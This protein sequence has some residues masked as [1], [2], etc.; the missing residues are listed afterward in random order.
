[1]GTDGIG[2]DQFA[3][4]LRGARSRSQIAVDRRLRVPPLIGVIVGAIAGLLP[5]LARRGPDALHRPDPHD[6]A[7]RRRR[8]AR[9]ATSA[10]AD[11]YRLGRDPRR[12]SR[13]RRWPASSAAEFLSLRE[14]E[15]V[16]AARA[17]GASN[18]RI[19]FK[20]MLPNVVGSIIVTA[21]LIMATAI[22][23]ETA[24]SFLGLGVKPPGH[25]A[26]HAG[27][28]ATRR[29]V[30]T[31]P[32]LFY[33]P[34]L[35][36]IL[37]ALCVN[38]IGDG[39]RDAFDPTADPGAGLMTDAARGRRPHR[40][41]PDRRRR[42]ARRP[43]RVATTL[44]PRRGARH[45]RRV[46]LGQVGVVAWRSWACCR[47]RPAYRGLD[48]V[49][50]PGA[51]R[52]EA[53]RQLQRLRGDEHRDDLPGPDDVAEPRV[54]GRAGSSPRRCAPTTTCRRRRPRTRAVEMLDLVGIPQRRAT[55]RRLPARVLRRHAPAGDDRHGDRQRPRRHHRRR[56]DHGP[57]RHRPG[58]DPR[59]AR[60]DQGRHRR[61]DHAHHPRP[62]RGR[63]HGRPDARDVRRQGRRDRARS[64]TSSTRPRMPYTLGL[65]GSIPRVDADGELLTPIQGRRRRSSTCRRAARSRPAARSCE[66]GLPRAPSPTCSRT[67]VR[68]A[69]GGLLPH[70]RV[71]AARGRPA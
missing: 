42:R 30:Q 37:I 29:S 2:Q 48:P 47:R 4:V 53:P 31:R 43:R 14:K 33:F 7:A 66:R 11:W 38:F 46:G 22:L 64:T 27:L 8:R 44:T 41:L 10:A 21:T 23:L 12:C 57:R 67:D 5:G 36:I 52:A 34:G 16:E 71:V 35:C 25:V 61:G 65:L 62:R 39:L 3:Q 55:G 70:R 60:D 9:P 32:W 54:H 45:R 15:F 40:R 59:D 56:A 6:P 49:P 18:R 28:R 17:I 1:M 24:L 51:R 50:R 63:R 20:H 69:P 58:P 19:I 68:R 26:R 13:G